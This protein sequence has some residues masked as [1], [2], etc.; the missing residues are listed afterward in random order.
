M[1]IATMQVVSINNLLILH[2]IN[3]KIDVR[4]NSKFCRIRESVELQIVT[5][6]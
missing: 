4:L 5:T 3:V 2:E 1:C 6:T